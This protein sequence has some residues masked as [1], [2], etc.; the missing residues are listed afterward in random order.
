MHDSR[1]VGHV[2]CR[3]R[4]GDVSGRGR[5][6]PQWLPTPR[7]TIALTALAGNFLFQRCACGQ[8]TASDSS[9]NELPEL[10]RRRRRCGGAALALPDLGWLADALRAAMTFAAFNGRHWR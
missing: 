2:A 4:W 7:W 8:R 6:P 1:L 3:R 10:H 9:G 5:T